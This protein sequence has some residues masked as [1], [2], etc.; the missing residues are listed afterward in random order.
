MSRLLVHVEG[1]TEETFVKEVLAPYLYGKGFENVGAR[2]V[3]N[4]RLRARRGGIRGWVSV[5]DDVVRHLKRDISAYATLMVDYYALPAS[6]S[7]EWP[8]RSQATLL[9]FDEKAASIETALNEDVAHVMGAGFQPQRFVPN[10]VMH[11][12]EGL[13]FS[14]CEAMARGMGRQNLQVQFQDIRD[15]FDSPE[16]INDS[17]LTAPSKRIEGLLPGYQKPLLGTLAAIEIGIG[18]MRENCRF[19]DRWIARLESI[20]A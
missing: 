9:P 10:I 20:M 5:R 13:L 7:R 8:G 1:E 17:P 6:G 15:S 18:P 11:E 12:F 14:D 2:I 3:G 16:H 4:A 19:F